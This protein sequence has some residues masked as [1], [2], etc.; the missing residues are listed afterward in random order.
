M[1]TF[2]D[3][4]G[5]AWVI[6]LNVGTIEK[7]LAET[8]VDMRTGDISTVQDIFKCTEVLWCLC[9]DQRAEEVSYDKFKSL[10]GGTELGAARAVLIE[11]WMSFI[12]SLDVVPPLLQK[13]LDE[14]AEAEKTV[15][16]TLK[17]TKKRNRRKKVSPQDTSPTRSPSGSISTS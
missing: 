9:K 12:Q 6:D 17:T 1:A 13:M 14:Q 16:E 15:E 11:E 10:L 4:L 3:K 7:V 8:D 5:N 2:N